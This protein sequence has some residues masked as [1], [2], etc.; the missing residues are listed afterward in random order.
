MAGILFNPRYVA[1]DTGTI[2]QMCKGASA[3]AKQLFSILRSG[4]WIPFLTYHH[5]EELACHENDDVFERRCDFIC[6]LP[7]VACMERA[8]RPASVGSIIDL[9]E[10]EIEFLLAN[11][12]ATHHEIIE[13]VRPKVR[14]GFYSG[15]QLLNEN[16][17]WL[18]FFRTTNLAEIRR[19]TKAETANLAHFPISD[20][21]EAV[22]RKGE[23]WNACS[24]QE[25][26]ANWKRKATWLKRQVDEHGDSRHMNSQ[27]LV[28][29][30]MS[31][32]LDGALKS[33][34][35]GGDVFENYL[36]E[37]QVDRNRLPT[38]ARIED[39]IYENVFVMNMGTHARNLLKN[40]GEM[41]KLI[42]K[43]ALP[44]WLIWQELD[45]HIRQLPNA[46]AGNLGDKDIAS[47]GPYLDV[48]NTDKRIA[49][50]LK[51]A[52]R[53][54]QLL[55]SVYQRVPERRGLKGLIETLRNN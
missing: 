28:R 34:A 39:V 21:K 51:Q 30:F 23:A 9:R 55:L 46:E 12:N 50:M 40:K 13:S 31:D 24:P 7:Q 2:D 22:P 33:L 42:R 29:N 48:L 54:D 43:E 38:N 20:M 27:E 41:L 32:V 35:G 6:T 5:L 25:A 17:Q 49:E 53:K 4:D 19:R 47:F 15:S 3:D 11:P 14:S 36:E 18:E 1:L 44:S 10:Y 26:I 16:R 37:A 45:R 8:G 52:G